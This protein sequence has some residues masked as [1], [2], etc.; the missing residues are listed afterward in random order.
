MYS[1]G[2]SSIS[3]NSRRRLL[4]LFALLPVVL[5]GV[6][7]LATGWEVPPAFALD[8][9]IATASSGAILHPASVWEIGQPGVNL[10]YHMRFVNQTGLTD[11]VNITYT[12]SPSV[13][14]VSIPSSLGTVGDGKSASFDVTVQM[15]ANSPPGTTVVVTVT[16]YL[17]ANPT[18]SDT[19]VLKE[20]YGPFWHLECVDC[21]KVFAQSSIVV[22]DQG[23]PHIAYGGYQ[24][25][26]SSETEHLYYAWF[27]GAMWRYETVDDS[28]RVGYWPTLVLDGN[29]YPH[30]AYYD[31]ENNAVKYAY[32]D[33]SGWHVETVDTRSGLEPCHVGFDLDSQGRPHLAYSVW[34]GNWSGRY[35]LLYAYNDGTGWS[36]ETAVE[37]YDGTW[38]SLAVDSNNRPHVVYE[39]DSDSAFMHAYRDGSTWTA[40]QISSQEP[41][42]P[43]IAIDS[44]DRMHVSYSTYDYSDR[45]YDLWY[46][47]YDGSNWITQTVEATAYSEG[48][49]HDIAVDQNGRPYI[50]YRHV[51]GFGYSEVRVAY[52]E[53]DSWN[54]QRLSGMT[55][56]PEYISIAATP[57]G[58]LHIS[59]HDYGDGTL[60][61][62]TGTA[63]GNWKDE[64]VDQAG[65]VGTYT[66][67]AMDSQGYPHIGYHRISYRD[68][69]YA[70]QD[71]KDWHVETV[72]DQNVSG[73][74]TSLALDSN[75]RPH[76]VFAY[77]TSLYYPPNLYYAY[78]GATG[79]I[80]E[81]IGSTGYENDIAVDGQGYP[82][83]SFRDVTNFDL[84]YAY[85]DASGWHIETVDNSGNVGKE[86]S[87]ALDQNGY[88]HIS[89]INWDNLDVKYA[90][91]DASGWHI[92]TVDPR[93]GYDTAIALDGSG[94]PHV[95]YYTGNDLVY[96]YRDA[97]GWITWTVDSFGDIGNYVS[98]ALDRNG[99]PHISYYDVDNKDLKYAY[100]DAEGW[101]IERVHAEGDVGQ[102]TSIGVDADGLPHISYYDEKNKDLRYAYKSDLNRLWVRE[103]GNGSGR[104]TSNPA[105]IDTGAGDHWADYQ[106][107]TVVTL[108]LSTASSTEF[109]GWGGDCTS[110]ITNTQCTVTMSVDRTCT[111]LLRMERA[112]IYL[113]LVVKNY[114]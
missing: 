84:L 113:P 52:K 112:Y 39:R 34:L 31:V 26:Y 19:S 60:T 85:K 56:D 66:S 62:I 37:D 23:R 97:S 110:C 70:Y 15:D 7:V 53:G 8:V 41:Q 28:A 98:I 2:Y 100:K 103:E 22:D 21:P 79:W 61:Y 49:H 102:Y 83:V 72:Y 94:R 63:G 82:H 109:L 10:T 76:M 17:A 64:T 58:Q 81:T 27:D 14:V 38:V 90:Y 74:Y 44:N 18:Y 50:A 36:F 25:G 69:K 24:E 108:T 42:K 30:I 105:G 48:K 96:A 29:G 47:Y 75:D 92:E 86:S 95:A 46:A 9:R 87:I 78:R 106:P 59:L 99:Y 89:Y 104:V 16:A 32:K 11:T 4:A 6:W 33:G 13:T 12:S 5:A 101:H 1:I 45:E 67:L 54:I 35:D 3:R 77:H 65:N 111:V 114:Q 91:K 71:G 57:A 20:V 107:N 93:W 43:S 80:T 55:T 73:E 40:E 51:G 68:A 88:P